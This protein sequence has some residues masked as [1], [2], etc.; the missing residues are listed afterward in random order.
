M[1]EF[2]RQNKNIIGIVLAVIL[3][4]GVGILIAFSNT[5]KY[6]TKVSGYT[7]DDP[8]APKVSISEESFDLGTVPYTP[9]TE[10]TIKIK[11]EGKSN[12]QLTDFKT[13]C[14]CTFVVLKIPG[15]ADSPKF[16]MHNNDT[17]Y[18][19]EL[20]PGTEAILVITFDPK[21]HNITGSVERTVFMNTND[22]EKPQAAINFKANVV[23][24]HRGH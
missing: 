15:K 20:E 12:L 16:E 9:P 13:S 2:V 11:N 23:E 1:N 22:P 10:K 19:G 18:V 6:E 3:T 14:G 24:D 5:G 4:I 17:G 7:K 8:N 21:A